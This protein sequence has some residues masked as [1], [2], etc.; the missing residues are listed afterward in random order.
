M[1]NEYKQLLQGAQTYTSRNQST[2]L[3]GLVDRFVVNLRHAAG[4]QDLYPCFGRQI[5]TMK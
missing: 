1:I 3:R 4:A 2:T 5:S